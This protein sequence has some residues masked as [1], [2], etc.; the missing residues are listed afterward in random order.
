MTD[1]YLWDRS[2]P[3]DPFVAELEEVLAPLAH[4]AGPRPPRR[5]SPLR[6]W[7]LPLAGAAALLI[8]VI[9]TLATPQP[10]AQWR[11]GVLAGAPRLADAALQDTRAWQTGAWL[12][13]DAES[14][15]HIES[16]QIGWLTVNP[17]SRL[18]LAHA[19]AHEH[20]LELA[21]G[22]IDAVILAPPRV[23]I[24]D[25]PAVTAVDMGCAYT[26]DVDEAGNGEIRVTAGWVYLER[27][28]V[29]AAMVPSGASCAIRAGLGAGTPRFRDAP[30]ALITGLERLDAGAADALAG[31][32]AAARPRDSLTVWHVAVSSTG[33]T[34]QAAIARLEELVGRP[35]GVPAGLDLTDAHLDRWWRRVV[36]AW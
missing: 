16:E 27:S 36:E 33:P 21:Q 2:G 29:P 35:R 8:A 15:A 12:E 1:D 7:A 19:D 11:A 4:K 22:S 17:D 25:T 26:L 18:R 14:K 28:G 9:V 13:T 10:D 24:V 32:L 5:R 20:R 6:S 34:R 3:P 31:V 30:Q 23:F